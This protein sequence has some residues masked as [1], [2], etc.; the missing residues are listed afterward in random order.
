MIL[1][2]QGITRF[3]ASGWLA[4]RC[5]HRADTST[6][7]RL[8]HMPGSTPFFLFLFFFLSL[9][10]PPVPN[11]HAAPPPE[12]HAAA[13]QPL[14]ACAMEFMRRAAAA[15]LVG[16][17]RVPGGLLPRAARYLLFLDIP[18]PALFAV[19]GTTCSFGN[20][21]RRCCWCYKHNH[22][23]APRVFGSLLP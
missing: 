8:L 2:S 3:S 16:C 12:P 17:C 6:C 10:Y 14:D 9:P 20:L 15:S 5:R 18:L 7:H 21:R 13:F 11:L 19:P 4:V 22:A 1:F 23:P